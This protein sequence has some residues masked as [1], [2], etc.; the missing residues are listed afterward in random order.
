MY[1][2]YAIIAREEK[3]LEFQGMT[4]TSQSLEDVVIIK[5]PSQNLSQAPQIKEYFMTALPD[6]TI[7]LMSEEIQF[8]RLK[9]LT[10]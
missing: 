6:K 2:S 10:Y 4:F 9:E 3:P 1:K 5:I 7:L 8:C